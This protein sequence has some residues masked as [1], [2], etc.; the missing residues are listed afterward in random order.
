MK[1]NW[2]IHWK[3]YYKILQVDPSAEQEVIEGAFNRLANKYHPDKNKS[4]QASERMKELNEAHDILKDVEKRKQYHARHVQVNQKPQN[5]T[6]TFSHTSQSASPPQPNTWPEKNAST[7]QT[8]NV[9]QIVGWCPNCK[10]I[11]SM[12]VAFIDKK[13]TYA[14][15]DRCKTHHDI[16]RV[17]QQQPQNQKTQSSSKTDKQPNYDNLTPD[18]KKRLEKIR[19]KYNKHYK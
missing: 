5:Y 8:S 1:E 15:C 12:K 13:P 14:Y 7:N 9:K 10:K 16:W 19:D 2:E 17:S 4:P 11:M 3:D 6:Q 18:M